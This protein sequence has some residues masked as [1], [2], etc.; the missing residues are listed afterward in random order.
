[1]SI[2]VD[3]VTRTNLTLANKDKCN[4]TL[5]LDTMAIHDVFS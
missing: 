5:S 2:R 3:A 4:K 1:M